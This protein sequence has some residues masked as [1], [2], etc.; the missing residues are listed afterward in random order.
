EPL[1]LG[2]Y[3]VLDRIRTGTFAGLCRALHPSTGQPAL[4]YICDAAT[5][6]IADWAAA[7]RH[8]EAKL[9][10]TYPQIGRIFGMVEAD[11]RRFL[12]LE[13]VSTSA[14]KASATATVATTSAPTIRSP[15]RAPVP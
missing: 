12:V 11:G 10:A 15:E 4:L 7:Q 2:D 8:A 13:D 6:S 14:S 5:H 9:Y 1:V 3:R